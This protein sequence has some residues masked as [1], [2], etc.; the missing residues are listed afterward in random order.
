MFIYVLTCKFSIGLSRFENMNLSPITIRNPN[1][2]TNSRFQI[3]ISP[4]IILSENV[5]KYK[6]HDRPIKNDFYLRNGRAIQK[7]VGKNK[8]HVFEN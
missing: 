1:L 5:Q 8:K 6:Y 2:L 3:E 7:A 4:Y